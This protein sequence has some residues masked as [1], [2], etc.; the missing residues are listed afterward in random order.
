MPLE[1]VSQGFVLLFNPPLIILRSA[2]CNRLRKLISHGESVSKNVC[3]VRKLHGR[4][5]FL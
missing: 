1:A 4:S 2:S 5:F 3:G